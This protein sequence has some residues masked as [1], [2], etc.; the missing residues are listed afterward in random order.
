M[1][2]S[3]SVIRIRATVDA[4]ALIGGRH[5][6][7]CSLQALETLVDLRS[8]VNLTAWVP[9]RLRRMICNGIRT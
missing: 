8:V 9:G 1:S 3:F 2:G 5:P 7:S 6:T 4:V